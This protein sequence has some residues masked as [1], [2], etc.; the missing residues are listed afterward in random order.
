MKLNDFENGPFIDALIPITGVRVNGKINV[1]G[2]G[3]SPV[4]VT[5]KDDVGGE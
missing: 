5:A 3:L 4:S 1:I 2:K